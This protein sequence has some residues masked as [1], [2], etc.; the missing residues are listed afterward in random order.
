MKV[1]LDQTRTYDKDGLRRR[2]ACLCLSSEDQPQILLVTSSRFKHLWIVPGGGLDPGE[3]PATA[4]VREIEEEAG[5]R[6]KMLGL[7]D[8]FENRES[9]TRTYVYVVVVENLADEYDDTKIGR[10]RRWF[11]LEDACR[12][13]H[14]YKP[15]QKSYI[16]TYMKR[17]ASGKR[18]VLANDASYQQLTPDTSNA[19]LSNN[20]SVL[21]VKS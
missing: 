21:D 1:K 5:A 18:L 14:L 6:G 19:I 12:Q 3:S 9:K 20:V 11:D 7:L 15:V 17:K 13:L 8:V 4:A 2:A 10:A 16:Q